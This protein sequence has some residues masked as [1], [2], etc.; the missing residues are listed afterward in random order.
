MHVGDSRLYLLR[1][2]RRV[3]R[4]RDHSTA[5][6]LVELGEISETEVATHPAQSCLYRSLGSE[7]SPRPDIGNECVQ[8]DDMFVLCSDGIWEQ[9]HEEALWKMAV[10]NNQLS[11][12]AA[13]L[14]DI[15]TSQGGSEADNAT[16][17]IIRPAKS[18]WDHWRGLVL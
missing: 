8:L 4:T 1:K 11:K 10:A 6:M 2:G 12:D 3:L 16:L 13:N 14:A 9:I 15:A 18:P 17:V 5:Q 7:E